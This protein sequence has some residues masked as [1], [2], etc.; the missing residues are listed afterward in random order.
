M[1]RLL[2]LIRA[3]PVFLR[4]VF[5][6][7][8]LGG[9]GLLSLAPPSALPVRAVRFPGGD[10]VA[11]FLMYAGLAALLRWATARRPPRAWVALALVA[12]YGLLMEVL[13]ATITGGTRFFSW[14]DVA[15]NALGA[16]VGWWLSRGL[17][18]DGGPA[19]ALL[20]AGDPLPSA[21]DH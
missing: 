5:C 15:A 11:H 13:Q 16:A 2:Q 8:Y 4:W 21:G 20:S 7:G 3:V 17:A 6:A 12:G 14:G 9:L 19:T 1:K 10:K 18:G